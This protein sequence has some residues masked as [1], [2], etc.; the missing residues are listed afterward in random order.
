MKKYYYSDGV[1]QHGPFT[2]EELREKHISRETLVWFQ[3]MANWQPA[4]TVQEL[5][6][7]FFMPPPP[8]TPPPGNTQ[9]ASNNMG[10]SNA[11]N[12]RIPKTWL[13]ES[14]LATLFCCL[15][16]GIVGIINASKVESRF[17]AG[18]IDEAIRCSEEAKK[19][20]MISFWIGIAVGVFYFVITFA[21][22]L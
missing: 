21:T 16:F 8:L 2:K 4:G 3:G 5:G 13:V 22:V 18:Q 6:D 20:T 12:T 17:Y 1:N 14:I 9:Y 15:P 19:W 10:T 7:I 11:N